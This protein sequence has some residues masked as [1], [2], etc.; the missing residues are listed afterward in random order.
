MSLEC[1]RAPGL[2]A[3]FSVV[4]T[5]PLNNYLKNNSQV[6][7]ILGRNSGVFRKGLGRDVMPQPA[8]NFYEFGPFRFYPDERSLLREGEVVPL[9][10]KVFDILLFLVKNH[11]HLL[12]K[13][14]MI[15]A[16]WPE[17][18]VEEGNLTRYISTLRQV[19]GEGQNGQTYIETVPR[20]GY[21]FVAEVREVGSEG[22]DPAAHSPVAVEE[23]REGD[24]AADVRQK[25]ARW[26]KA[27]IAAS[28]AALCVAAWVYFGLGRKEERAAPASIKSIAVLPFKPLNRSQDDEYLGIG[29]ADAVITRLSGAGKIIVR[30]TGS[31]SKYTAS[32]QDPL[33]AGREQQVDAVLDASLWRSGEKVRVTARLLRVQ[34]GMPLW[35][36]QCEELCT[37]VFAMQT[38]I[39]EQVVGALM[40]QLTSAERARLTKH[41]TED[42]EANRLYT[43]G[44]FYW[45]KRTE[46]ALKKG[47]E[48]FQQ[49]VEIDPNYALAYAGLAECYVALLGNAYGGQEELLPKAKAY[50]LKAMEIDSALAEAHSALAGVKS[51]EWDWPGAEKEYQLAIELNPGYATAYQRYSYL[52]M[53]MGRF[54]ESF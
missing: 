39:S 24:E 4:G 14:T 44:R 17:S 16:I 29:L 38:L 49:A 2:R 6:L 31:V 41:Y 1:T 19:L 33:V 37:D 13:D 12:Q 53:R 34:D 7:R 45:N 3:R 28:V 21:R 40:S 25:K 9:P 52:L 22:L 18:F 26:R 32:A 15:K 27:A 10:P 46:Q 5:L 50:A 42:H 23:K 48:C 54:E 35:T 43:L 51:Y 47:I 20:I 11:G 8:K 30:S 36:W